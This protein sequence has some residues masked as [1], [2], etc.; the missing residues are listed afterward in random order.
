MERMMD[1]GQGMKT[2]DMDTV[3]G[4]VLVVLV[5]QVQRRNTTLQYYSCHSCRGGRG[6]G[7]TDFFGAV[8]NGGGESLESLEEAKMH[9][10]D[11]LSATAPVLATLKNDHDA[12]LALKTQYKMKYQESL[13]KNEILSKELAAEKA[14]RK[15]LEEDA[16]K[17]RNDEGADGEA[18]QI[19]ATETKVNLVQ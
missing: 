16:A 9:Y 5:V 10:E 6:T 7:L 11:L 14:R 18:R 12:T 3:E 8:M 1:I 4:L 2:E 19:C 13:G 15:S 17:Y